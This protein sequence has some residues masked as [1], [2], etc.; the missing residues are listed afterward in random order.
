MYIRPEHDFRPDDDTF[1]Y[2]PDNNA[3][4]LEGIVPLAFMALMVVMLVWGLG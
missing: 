2:R 3:W 4:R 1:D